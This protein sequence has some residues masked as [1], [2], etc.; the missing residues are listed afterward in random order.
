MEAFKILPQEIVDYC[1]S[2][3][4]RYQP[5]NLFKNLPMDLVKQCLSYDRRFVIRH[6]RIYQINKISRS[7]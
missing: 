7:D 2:Y 5:M 4:L 3:D 6:G 1:L